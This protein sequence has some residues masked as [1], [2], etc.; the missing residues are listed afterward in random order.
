MKIVVASGKGGTGKSM[1]ASSLALLFSEVTEVI[2]CDCDVDAPNLGLW[3][4]VTTYDSVEGVSTSERARINPEKCIGCGECFKNCAFGAIEKMDSTFSINPL[5]CE[6]CGTCQLVCPTGAIDLTPV[7]NGEIRV[8]NTEWGFALVSGQLHPGTSGS[9]KIVRELRRRAE[10]LSYKVMVLDAA[11]G[12]GCPVIASITGC[13]YAV[14]VTEPTPSGFSDLERVLGTVN[15]FGIP[16]GIV[17]NKWDIN[18]GVSRRIEEWSGERFLGKIRYDR[19]VVN[20]IVNLRPVILSKSK[21]K[22]EIREI[23]GR[24]RELTSSV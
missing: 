2:A 6:G 19:E 13:D 12:V 4:G 23:F 7:V 17:L 3:L 5:L 9:G 1:F 10:G 21:V 18:P 24:I 22:N 15:H 11:A 14:L 8:K 16:Y 20:S